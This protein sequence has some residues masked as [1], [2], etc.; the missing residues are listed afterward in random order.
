LYQQQLILEF[1]VNKAIAE[2]GIEIPAKEQYEA[3][4]LLVPELAS[5]QDQFRQNSIGYAAEIRRILIGMGYPVELDFT[6][7]MLR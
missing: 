7:A 2:I 3:Y 6:G 4:S 1:S 5:I